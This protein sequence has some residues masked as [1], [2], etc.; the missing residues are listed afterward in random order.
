MIG[1]SVGAIYFVIS[2][3]Q[4]SH[5]NVSML[6]NEEGFK[7]YCLIACLNGAEARVTWLDE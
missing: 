4:S 5:L 1:K 2:A 3:G 6:Y 7:D